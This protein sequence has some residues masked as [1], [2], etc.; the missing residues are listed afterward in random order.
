MRDSKSRAARLVGSSPTSGTK[1]SPNR[2]LQ[3]YVIGLAIG[4][5]NLSNS[6]GRAVR[7]RISCDLKY[8]N[9]INTIIKSLKE[10]FPNNQISTIKRGENCLD[11]S[12]YSNHLE[13]L[14]GW[15]AKEGSKFKQD[16]TVPRWIKENEIYSIECLRGLFQTDGCIYFDRGYNMVNFTTIIE[17]LALDVM[18]MI[19]NLG[20][21]AH[22][23][24]ISTT[25]TPKY[26]IRV[27]HRVE[28][29][30]SLLKLIKG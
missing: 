2:R 17:R 12:C 10:L 25:K 24:K 7:L 4:D 29:F 28:D 15:K 3:A 9:L 6:N 27:S 5:G 1:I 19:K 18:S 26:I 20:F 23:Y 22:V 14:L 11:V 8:P 13:N 16:V 30:I 21:K